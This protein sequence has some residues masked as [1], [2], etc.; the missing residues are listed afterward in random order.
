MAH[1]YSSLVLLLVA[2]MAMD[3]AEDNDVPAALPMSLIGDGHQ[4]DELFRVLVGS[5]GT[6]P[7]QGLQ[8]VSVAVVA[9]PWPGVAVC[10]GPLLTSRIGVSH[11]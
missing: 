9:G 6:V 7:G 1:R 5:F 11:G 10:S 4:L 3:D 2:A 8:R